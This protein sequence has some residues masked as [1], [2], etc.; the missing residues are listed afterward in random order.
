MTD[1]TEKAFA[2]I[3]EVTKQVIVL[4]TAV[5]TLSITFMK[6]FVVTAH[7]GR[8]LLPTSWLAFLLSIVAGLWTLLATV[9]AQHKAAENSCTPDPYAK[10]MVGPAVVQLLAFAAGVLLT[11]VAGWRSL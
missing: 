2:L 9:G 1:W 4:S 10:N 5:I 7:A 6:D 11:V 3:V 8:T